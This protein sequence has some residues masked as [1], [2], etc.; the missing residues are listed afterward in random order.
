MTDVVSQHAFVSFLY[1]CESVYVC[2]F[3]FTCVCVYA[4][5]LHILYC[6]ELHEVIVLNADAISEE[7]APIRP[8]LINWPNQCYGNNY[9]GEQ[10]SVCVCVKSQ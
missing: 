7:T 4:C 3:V 2:K 1:A 6:N 9:K 5:V 8:F 10:Q